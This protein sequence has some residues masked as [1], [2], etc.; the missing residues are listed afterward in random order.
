VSTLQ[1]MGFTTAQAKKALRETVNDEK[2]NLNQTYLF[3]SLLPN[4]ILE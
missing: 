1:D 2:G 3:Y 4:F